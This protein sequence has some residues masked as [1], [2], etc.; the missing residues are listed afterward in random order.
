MEESIHWLSVP[1]FA[2][3][4][5]R[6]IAGRAACRRKNVE[7]LLVHDPRQTEVCN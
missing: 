4:F 3:D 2:K 5:R 1:T 7:L 6:H